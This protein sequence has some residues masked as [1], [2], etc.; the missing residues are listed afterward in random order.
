MA[1][2]H[3]GVSAAG[4]RCHKRDSACSPRPLSAQDARDAKRR[5]WLPRLPHSVWLAAPPA[6]PPRRMPGGL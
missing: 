2:L 4:R 1:S 5:W 6:A 3:P